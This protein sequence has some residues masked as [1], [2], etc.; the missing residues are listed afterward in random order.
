MRH[1]KG[2]T[3]NRR[4]HHALKEER[5]AKC[6]SCGALHRRHTVCME[7]GKYRDREVV[8]VEAIRERTRAR[9]E[10]K[11]KAIGEVTGQSPEPDRE[12]KDSDDESAEKQEPLSVEE[13][14]KK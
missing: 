14:S 2:H 4:S 6:V 12:E 3:K 1:T 13:L 7:C 10:A 8:D 9:K 11:V 5:M